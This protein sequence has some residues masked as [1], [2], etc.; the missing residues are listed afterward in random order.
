MPNRSDR[1]EPLPSFNAP[2]ETVISTVDRGYLDTQW[3]KNSM[4]ARN[5]RSPISL[6]ALTAATLLLPT[7]ATAD[8][9]LGDTSTDSIQVLINKEDAVRISAMEDVDFGSH[10][11]L[12]LDL[13]LPEL[14][15]VFASNGGFNITGSTANSNNTSFQMVSGANTLDYQIQI[16]TLLEPVPVAMTP[17]VS[18]DGLTGNN[19]LDNCGNVPNTTI[20]LTVA[21][22]DF[23]AAAPGQYADTLTMLVEPE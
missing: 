5:N 4:Q 12:N 6:V 22:A 16:S 8:G 15:C 18:V 23:N 7:L 9:V 21:A 17:G 13:S 14:F 11:S 20:L 2:V 19:L 1:G 10:A 3:T